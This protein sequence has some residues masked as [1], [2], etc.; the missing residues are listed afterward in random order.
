MLIRISFWIQSC[1]PF[2]S[3][4]TQNQTM[5]SLDDGTSTLKRG[6]VTMPVSIH[7]ITAWFSLPRN[8]HHPSELL[9][10]QSQPSADLSSWML[11]GST[12]TS[13]LNSERIPHQKNTSLTSQT[14]VGP[15]TQMVY[16]ITLDTSMSQ[17]L[18]ISN[19]MFFNIHMI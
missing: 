9:L 4:K 19:H 10:Y 13:G 7:R 2:P 5:H 8:W 18:A 6:I 17:T 3:Q 16:F 15:W 11:K 14:P 1:Y 12:P